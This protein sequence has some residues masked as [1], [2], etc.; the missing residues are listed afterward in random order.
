VGHLEK[1]FGLVV[2]IHVLAYA[3]LESQQVGNHQKFVLF[4]RNAETVV[5]VGLELTSLAF[6][7]HE[8]YSQIV[9]YNLVDRLF[10]LNI[11]LILAS[12][13]FATSLY[14]TQYFLAC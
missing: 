13:L 10:L 11:L 9:H 5:E 6:F 14:P 7:K 4:K 8:Q 2:V 12:F 3:G 1:L